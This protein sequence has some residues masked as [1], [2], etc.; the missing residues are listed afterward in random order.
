MWQRGILNDNEWIGWLRFMRRAFEQGTITE[1]WKTVE[2]R[3]WLDPAF[4]E[5]I[6][7]ELFNK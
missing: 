2:P 5:F 7:K 3:K 4:E 1:I 6:N